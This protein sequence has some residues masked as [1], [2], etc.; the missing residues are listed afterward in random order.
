MVMTSNQKS[1]IVTQYKQKAPLGAFCFVKMRII[2]C[3][4]W[5]L[6][7]EL[8][9]TFVKCFPKV[10]LFENAKKPRT[11]DCSGLSGFTVHN[12]NNYAMGLLGAL[13]CVMLILCA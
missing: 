9:L 5:W 2:L 6:I 12:L 13:Y 3:S 11:V 7:I 1:L 4:Q 8:D 10:I